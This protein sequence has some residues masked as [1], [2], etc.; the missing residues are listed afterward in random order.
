MAVEVLATVAPQPPSVPALTWFWRGGVEVGTWK[1][2][3]AGGG[4]TVVE[5]RAVTPDGGVHEIDSGV[6]VSVD[7]EGDF[8][9]DGPR[10]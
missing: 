2:G 10:E 3:V 8:G 1:V 9:T 7:H 4:F 6:G 5:P